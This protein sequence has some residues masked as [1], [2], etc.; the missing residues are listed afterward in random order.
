[1][2]DVKTLYP[3]VI[4]EQP[5]PQEGEAEVSPSQ[6]TTTTLTPT[7]IKDKGFPTK[8]IAVELIGSALNTKSRKI[9]A[10]FA[11][12]ETGALQIGKYVN[13]VSGDIRITPTGIVMRDS[14]GITTVA[15]YAEDGSAVFKGTIQAGSII[16]SGTLIAGDDT[17]IID[18][19]EGHGRMLFYDDDKVAILLGW[20]DF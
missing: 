17:V 8:R 13:G 2:S 9:L 4:E 18:S 19:V 20:G 5:F 16:S 11:L 12:T 10:E 15:Q 6:K 7:T 3:E 14:A 1:M